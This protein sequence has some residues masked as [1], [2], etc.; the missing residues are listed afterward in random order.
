M[1]ARSFTVERLIEQRGDEDDIS[2][3]LNLDD[4]QR[5]LRREGKVSGILALSCTCAEGRGERIR[6]EL[7]GVLPGNGRSRRHHQQAKHEHA[8]HDTEISDWLKPV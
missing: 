8:A 3:L 1:L 6:E 4:A 5:A 7:S 2:I